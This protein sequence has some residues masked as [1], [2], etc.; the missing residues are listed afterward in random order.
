MIDWKPIDTFKQPKR[1]REFLFWQ[2]ATNSG[3]YVL[4]ARA[5]VGTCPPV[6]RMT[7]HW[8]EIN[9]PGGEA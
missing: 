8:A 2:P 6:P 1:P 7:T 9:A 5:V 4:A 3:R